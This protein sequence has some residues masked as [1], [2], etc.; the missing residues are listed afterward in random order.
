MHL[1]YFL[2]TLCMLWALSTLNL[3]SVHSVSDA[4][5]IKYFS[6]R[7]NTLFRHNKGSFSVYSAER[8]TY[9][10]EFSMLLARLIFCLSSWEIHLLHMSSACYLQ[11]SFSVC[12]AERCR[13]VFCLS[14]HKMQ[15]KA[16]FLF[17]QLRDTLALYEFSMLLTQINT[18]LNQKLQLFSL[19]RSFSLHDSVEC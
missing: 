8:C 2:H 11:G 10:H 1:V 13:L 7:Q 14:S 12:L 6:S 16:Y 18:L 17:I 4:C 3:F 15:L 9:L 19:N 5:S